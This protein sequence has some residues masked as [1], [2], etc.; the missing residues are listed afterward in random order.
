MFWEYCTN[1]WYKIT[2]IPWA[3]CLVQNLSFIALVNDTFYRYNAAITRLG[4]GENTGEVCKSPALETNSNWSNILNFFVA[5]LV[6][7]M[8]SKLKWWWKGLVRDSARL[9]R[10][11]LS[12][13]SVTKFQKIVQETFSN[14]V[15]TII[16]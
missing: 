12:Q 6:A 13:E 11:H 15:V 14:A 16:D 5:N 2:Q 4:C 8:L 1:V 9:L 7:H 3:S 10:S